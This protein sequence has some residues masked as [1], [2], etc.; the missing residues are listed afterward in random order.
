M[1]ALTVVELVRAETEVR[2]VNFEILPLPLGEGWGEGLAR[3]N[4]SLFFSAGFSRRR[5]MRY[6][7][8]NAQPESDAQ[9]SECVSSESG[10][11]RIKTQV[12]RSIHLATARGTD[13]IQSRPQ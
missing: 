7:H 8:Y 6:S 12:G 3:D 2:L 5:Q 10:S 1:V 11:D 9:P 4:P 13:T